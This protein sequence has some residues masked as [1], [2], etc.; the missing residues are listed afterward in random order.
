MEWGDPGTNT[1]TNMEIWIKFLGKQHAARKKL[2]DEWIP[3]ENNSLCNITV[4]I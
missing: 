2:V 4:I 1:P 3:R